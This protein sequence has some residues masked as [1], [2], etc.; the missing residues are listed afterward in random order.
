MLPAQVLTHALWPAVQFTPFLPGFAAAI[1][2]SRLGGQNAGLIS[3]AFGVLAYVVFPPPLAAAGYA[4]LIVGFVGLSGA[5]SWVIARHYSIEEAL[6][7]SEHRLKTIIDAQPACV[8][9][10]SADGHLLEMNSAGLRMIGATQASEVVGAAVSDLIHPEDRAR[11][12]AAHR[13]ATAGSPGRLEFR[14]VDFQQNERWVDS[15]MVPFEPAQ[16]GA[17]RSVLSVTSD[18]TE[19]KQLEQQLRHA[20]KMEAIGRLAGGVAHD[21][22][23]ALTVITGLA[24]S[25]AEQVVDNPPLAEDLRIVC[26]AAHSAAALTKQLLLFSRRQVVETTAVNLNAVIAKVEHLIRRTIGEDIRIEIRPALHVSPIM[27]DVAQLQQVIMN[28]VV[29]A[30]DAMPTGG[31]LIIETRNTELP[32]LLAQAMGLAPGRYVELSVTDSGQGIDADT[33]VRMFEPFFT[34]KERGRGT[35]LGLSTVYGIVRNFGG[36]I[37]VNSEVGCGA[38]FKVY[39]PETHREIA[40]AQPEEASPAAANTGGETILLVEDDDSVRTFSAR[41]LRRAGYE[42][43]EASS[44]ARGLEIARSSQHIDAMLT[45]IV[46]PDMDGCELARCARAYR[47]NMKVL[48]MSGYADDAIRADDL[49]LSPESLLEKPFTAGLLLRRIRDVLSADPQREL[50]AAAVGRDH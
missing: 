45:D 26:D 23:N 13:A 8:K 17:W 4:G 25:A 2:S 41:V 9:L 28:L 20:Q 22:N 11:F 27:G 36:S 6:R 37:L 34:T 38:T 12:L 10:V 33:K 42:V 31:Q 32:Y 5:F 3:I 15:H 21:F 18:V 16:N 39:F 49:S 46:M 43:L 47:S 14:I 35:G 1:L 44:P 7:R 30:R 24:E 29:N 19:R 40:A 50:S 48:F